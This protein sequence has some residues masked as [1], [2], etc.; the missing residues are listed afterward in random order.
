MSKIR[1]IRVIPL[2]FQLPPGQAYGSARGLTNRRGGGL[3][4]L[5][6][7]DGIQGIGEAW[8]PPA[9]SRAYLE[10]IKPLYIGRSVFAQ[11]GAAQTALARMYHFGTQNQLIALMGGIDIAAHDAMGKLLNLSV[12]DLIGGR[13]RER[14][15]VYASGGYF[16]EAD[17]QDM[18]LARQLEP[19]AARGFTAFKIKIGR[20]P[21]EDATRAALA[22]R[23]IGE[24]PLLTVDT[25]GNYTEDGV[26]ESMRRTAPFDIHW[27]EEPLAPQDWAGYASLKTRASVPLATGE[28][29]YGVFDFRRLIDARLVSVVQPDLTLCGGFDVARTIGVLCAAEHLRI[30]PHVWGTGIGLAAA[31]HFV[32]S[33]PNYPHG[34]HVPFPP[35][36]EY[37]VGHNALQNDIFIEPL[38]Y[39]DGLVEVP[40]GPGL[41]VS[42][43]D[44]AVRRF[45]PV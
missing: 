14:V 44:A 34:A 13:Q 9:V 3:V 11:R 37:D 43:N 24:T 20:H 16:T 19:N 5:D 39:V 38:R 2:E 25:N 41:G 33:L 12:A 42:L 15:P 6:T 22:R 1:D 18:A 30:S 29:L 45:S 10:L 8:G 4:I 23:I 35:L 26:L 7:E 32:A 40:I 27:Y 21:A 17:D 31:V 28:A 36:V